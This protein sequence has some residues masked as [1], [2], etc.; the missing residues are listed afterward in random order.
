VDQ[1]EDPQDERCSPAGF[2]HIY[3]TIHAYIYIILMSCSNWFNKLGRSYFP[4]SINMARCI[5]FLVK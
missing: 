1:K 4:F 3:T 5:H 2:N